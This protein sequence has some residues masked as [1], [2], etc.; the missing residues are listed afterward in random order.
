MHIYSSENISRIVVHIVV[1]W[2]IK[3]HYR[4]NPS[5]SCRRGEDQTDTT[6]TQIGGDLGPRENIEYCYLPR[7]FERQSYLPHV[8]DHTLAKY[9][10]LIFQPY[11]INFHNLELYNVFLYE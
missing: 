2:I 7:R 11:L 3:T 9:F 6:Q 4:E 8:K 5:P 1:S 10:I